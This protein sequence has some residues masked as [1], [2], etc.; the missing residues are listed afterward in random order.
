MNGLPQTL[1]VVVL[2]WA[3]GFIIGHQVG[4]H[5]PITVMNNKRAVIAS[6]H[7][8]R[9][10][11]VPVKRAKVLEGH[12]FDL[13]LANGERYL[14]HL[15]GVRGT[16]SEAKEK[17]VRLLNEH[18]QLGNPLTVLLRRW[19]DVRDRWVAVLYYDGQQSLRE[20]LLSQNLVYQS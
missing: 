15:E 6:E 14:V 19:D 2:A 16:P 9:G 11:R 12:V 13:V 7:P 5:D 1:L 18:R 10:L 20:W 3:G 4:L 17:V 8:L